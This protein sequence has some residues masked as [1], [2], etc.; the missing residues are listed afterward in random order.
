MHSLGMVIQG[1][2]SIKR[3]LNMSDERSIWLTPDPKGIMSKSFKKTVIG[4]KRRHQSVLLNLSS[5]L[6]IPAS[7]VGKSTLYSVGD[8]HFI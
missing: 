8:D 2:V 1:K 6:Q 7:L 4:L 3:G 5:P